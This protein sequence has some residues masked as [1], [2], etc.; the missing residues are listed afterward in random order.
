VD[1]IADDIEAF[2]MVNTDNAAIQQI[3]TMAAAFTL[4]TFTRFVVAVVR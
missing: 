1:N 2:L 3:K 4:V